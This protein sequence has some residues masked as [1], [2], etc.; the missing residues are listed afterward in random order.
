MYF[1]GRFILRSLFFAEGSGLC[2]Q[3]QGWDDFALILQ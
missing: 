1:G 3:Q 2:E